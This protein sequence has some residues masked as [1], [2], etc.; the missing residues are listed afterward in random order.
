VNRAAATTSHQ[1]DLKIEVACHEFEFQI[2]HPALPNRRSAIGLRWLCGAWTYGTLF[3]GIRGGKA[4]PGASSSKAREFRILCSG[5][6]C[7]AS[8]RNRRPCRVC[9]RQAAAKS[10]SSIAACHYIPGF[11]DHRIRPVGAGLHD[12]TRYPEASRHH[13]RR[14]QLRVAGCL[15]RPK[16]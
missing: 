13:R 6:P 5:L 1:V 14:S 9:G 7:G 11:D 3:D 12:R 2:V 15:A 16:K 10:W 8:C 4:A